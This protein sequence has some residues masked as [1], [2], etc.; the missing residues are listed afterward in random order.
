[1]VASLPLTR[2]PAMTETHSETSIQ[3]LVDEVVM[4]SDLE[5]DPMRAGAASLEQT[6]FVMPTAIRVGGVEL[7]QMPAQG[8]VGIFLGRIDGSVELSRAPAAEG[9]WQGL[10]LLGTVGALSRLMCN[11]R[12]GNSFT[13]NLAFGW[14]LTWSVRNERVHVVSNLSG[15]TSSASIGEVAVAHRAFSCA[16]RARALG[17]SPG[18]RVAR[19]MEDLVSGCCLTCAP[20]T[21]VRTGH[22][23]RTG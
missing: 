6:Y 8:D 14:S 5:C 7:L 1:M 13:M 12:A 23:F 21:R 11:I 9:R 16:V 20:G 18:S 19:G 22:H 2:C 4:R 15:R 3:F 17:E 10:P